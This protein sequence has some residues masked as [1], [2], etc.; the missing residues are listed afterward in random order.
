M[1]AVRIRKEYVEEVRKLLFQ[2][3]LVDPTRKFIKVGSEVEIPVHSGNIQDYNFIKAYEPELARQKKPIRFVPQDPFENI[4]QLVNIPAELKKELPKKWE[5]LGSVL[6]LKIPT[7][8]EEF[9]TELAQVY[10]K[11]LKAKTVVKDLGIYGERREPRVK[12]LFGVST[13]TIHRENKIKFK[14][15]VSQLMFSS[16]NLE[17]RKRI[18]KI[19]NKNEVVVD[20]FAGIGYFSI[21]LTV[22]SKPKKVIAYEINPIAYKY[23]CENIKLNKVENII[24]PKLED[25]R[26][27]Q[28]LVADRIIMGYLKKTEKYLPKALRVLKRAGGIIHYHQTCPNELISSLAEK[29]NVIVAKEGKKAELLKLTKVKSYAPGVT[30]LV[31]DLK[32]K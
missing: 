8:L 15:D 30:H 2:K 12:K 3:G 22:Y 20:M 16:G 28:E 10:A 32:I 1:F 7:R 25:C 24:V 19:S 23:L 26:N 9:E 14:L 11:A 27:A 4:L 31:L 6:L 13:E 21:P 18:A 29:V 5:K 17:E